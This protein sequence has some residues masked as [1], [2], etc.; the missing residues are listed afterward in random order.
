VAIARGLAYRSSVLLMDEPFGSVD[1]QTRFELED[2]TLRLRR[3]LGLTV[4]V[5]THDID[6]AVYLGDRVIVLAGQPASVVD[7]LGIDLGSA[8][9]QLTTRADPRFAELRSRV[10]GEIRGLPAE[11]AAGTDR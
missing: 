11:A 1:A 9:D 7:N 2:L 5:V 4:V 8:R 3:E 10:L 6:E